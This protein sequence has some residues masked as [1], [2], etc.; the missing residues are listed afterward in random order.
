[1]ENNH[2]IEQL[3][4]TTM[5]NLIDMIDVNTV[6]GDPVE[7]K[8][9]TYIIP[10]SKVSFG[11]ASGGSEFPNNKPVEKSDSRFAFGGGSGAG[12]SVKPVAFLIVKEDTVKILPIDS[13]NPYDR[14]VDSIPNVLDSLKDLFKNNN[15]SNV[16]NNVTSE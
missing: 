6:I 14:L 8:D 13:N 5:E 2:P 11:F 9:G 16:D 3:M 12:V 4:S 15:T 1:M 7:T 10:I